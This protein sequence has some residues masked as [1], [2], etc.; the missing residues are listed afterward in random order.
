M[1]DAVIVFVKCVLIIGFGA[2]VLSLELADIS[3]VFYCVGLGMWTLK[4][5]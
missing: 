2:V 5:V 4:N 3:A 1:I